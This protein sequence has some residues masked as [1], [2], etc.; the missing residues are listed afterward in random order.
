MLTY[1]NIVACWSEQKMFDPV[2]LLHLLPE[3]SLKGVQEPNSLSC[4]LVQQQS[5]QS[6]STILPL[7]PT[8]S[9][10]NV[11]SAPIV[12][13][14][15]FHFEIGMVYKREIKTR[16]TDSKAACCVLCKPAFVG[17]TTQLQ[18]DYVGLV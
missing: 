10:A 8:P 17:R 2:D 9:W 1:T 16:H 15:H 4:R 3:T 18:V 11:I 5:F 7:A 13:L 6:S 14:F 12:V